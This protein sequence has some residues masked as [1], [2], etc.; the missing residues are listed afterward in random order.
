[1]TESWKPI[2]GWEGYYEASDHGRIRSINRVVD[3]SDGTTQR[4]SGQ[5]L[6][7]GSE[8]RGRR[9]H[10]LWR[11]GKA[12]NEKAHRLVMMTFKGPCPSGL[13]VCHRD[14]DPSNNHLNNLYYGTQSDNMNDRVR[15]G[16]HHNAI[17]THCKYGHKYSDDNI[18]WT[19]KGSR[20]CKIC[21]KSRA[22]IAAERKRVALSG[23]PEE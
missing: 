13:E 18:Y 7:G 20:M 23:V 12:Y 21:A 14:D 5:V 11:D 10:V 22:A 16:I 19:A 6:K 3:K 9:T 8:Q 2:P 4:V 1:M 15:N 17:K